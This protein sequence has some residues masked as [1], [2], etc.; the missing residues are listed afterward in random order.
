MNYNSF[1][2]TLAVAV[3]LLLLLPVAGGRHLGHDLCSGRALERSFAVV[4][5]SRDFS[6]GSEGGGGQRAPREE[7]LGRRAGD[8]GVDSKPTESIATQSRTS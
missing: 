4:V 6:G 8:G 1:Q 2:C 7:E 3:G 5:A